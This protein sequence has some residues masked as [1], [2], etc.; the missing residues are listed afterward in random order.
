MAHIDYM[1]HLLSRLFCSELLTELSSARAELSSVDFF[2]CGTVYYVD[3]MKN[4]A[5]HPAGDP[6][7]GGKL[8]S[9]AWAQVTMFQVLG[10]M[11]YV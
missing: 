6:P 4:E 11:S 5:C 2:S 10:F 7:K 3:N 9:I 8:E 1:S